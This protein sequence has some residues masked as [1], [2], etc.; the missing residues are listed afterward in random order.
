MGAVAPSRSRRRFV[1][2][3]IVVLV[4][5][6]LAE[7]V[8]RVRYVERPR[9]TFAIPE[10]EVEIKAGQLDGLRGSG[11]GDVYFLGSSA[12]DVA[13]DPSRLRA[14]SGDG[15]RYNAATMG[16][17]LHI[18]RLWAESVVLQQQHPQ[19]VVVG[20]TSR[21]MFGGR[22]Q[23]RFEAQF[24]ASPTV[25]HFVGGESVLEKSQW[26]AGRWSELVRYRASLREV[27]ILKEMVGLA[28]RRKAPTYFAPGRADARVAVRARTRALERPGTTRSSRS[29][30]STG[31][32][33]ATRR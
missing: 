12:V 14:V 8:V 31:S 6:V 7:L 16:S 28:P 3:V 32:A 27:A 10:K 4:G 11:S 24:L 9:S 1:T 29:R 23:R 33:S 30:C 25:H 15:A 19:F 18:A 17:T 5:L 13:I 22:D 26:Y 2:I 21:D 20:V